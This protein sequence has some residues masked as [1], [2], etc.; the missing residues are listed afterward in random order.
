MVAADPEASDQACKRPEE[1]GVVIT[2]DEVDVPKTG[3]AD[4]GR[5]GVAAKPAGAG[6][7]QQLGGIGQE[8]DAV[9]FEAGAVFP[10]WDV[11]PEERHDADVMA[12]GALNLAL[13][14]CPFTGRAVAVERP[15]RHSWPASA[16]GDGSHMC[17]EDAASA[18]FS[19][20]IPAFAKPTFER[21]GRTPRT[22]RSTST[23]RPRRSPSQTQPPKPGT[24]RT[25]TA[26]SRR[27]G[28]AAGLCLSIASRRH[29]AQERPGD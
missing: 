6:P 16:G 14:G 13:E 21:L 8:R 24:H 23:P 7:V 4:P 1:A 17:V 2:V 3:P 11:E 12:D 27:A 15:A 19:A 26:N 29:L 18:Q 20:D 9:A 10:V 28:C 22:S 5:D 25:S